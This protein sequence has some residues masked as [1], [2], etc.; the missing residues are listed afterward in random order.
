M[1]IRRIL[2]Q[3]MA[4]AGV[5]FPAVTGKAVTPKKK[6]FIVHSYD[7]NHICG[8]P[9][10]EGIVQEFKTRNVDVEYQFH[11]MDTRVTNTTPEAKK[12]TADSALAAINTF[13]PDFVF[14]LDDDAFKYVGLSLADKPLKV[15]FSG[16]NGQPSDYHKQTPFLDEKGIPNKNITGVYE[17]LHAATSFRTM[18][19]VLPS[20]KKIVAVIDRTITG[21]ATLK[22]LEIE[23]ANEKLPFKLEIIRVATM[24]EY[25]DAIKKI[26]ADKE[27][28][29]V[30]NCALSLLN[31][32]GKNVTTA[33]TFKYYLENSKIP[34]IAVNYDFARIGL[35]GGA[36]VNFTT[37]GQQAARMALKIIDGKSVSSL[38]IENDEKYMLVFN[39]ATANHINVK[40]PKD[41]EMVAD[42]V[43]DSIPLLEKKK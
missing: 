15:I 42:I 40:I 19:S 13:K 24:A 22:Q 37:M 29:A 33:V 38:P 41:I 6:V 31:D 26:N 43:Y 25:R 7:A 11:Y 16:L 4:V 20:M 35:F 17:F 34:A 2:I 30:Y 32:D 8:K 14:T 36:A 1:S 23:L 21:D 18:N 5:M 3:S 39:R 10:H 12:K 9:Q 27:V 28:G